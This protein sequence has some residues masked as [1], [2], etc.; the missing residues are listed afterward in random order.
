MSFLS[1]ELAAEALHHLSA[2]GRITETVLSQVDAQRRAGYL[3][4]VGSPDDVRST[5]GVLHAQLEALSRAT[6]L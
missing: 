6:A 1:Q 2:L 4:P 5:C 3:P